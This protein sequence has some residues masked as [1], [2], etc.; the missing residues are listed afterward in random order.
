MTVLMLMFGGRHA[1]ISCQLSGTST[2]SDPRQ[3]VLIVK[4]FA[5]LMVSPACDCSGRWGRGAAALDSC[6]HW[7]KPACCLHWPS[8]KLGTHMCTFVVTVTLGMTEELHIG[9]QDAKI[10]GP[11]GADST[12]TAVPILCAVTSDDQ[13]NL[14]PA[15]SNCSLLQ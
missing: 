5:H 8:A 3:F 11:G 9:G 12:D 7:Q 13:V 2:N 10:N 15:T 4:K 1:L 14:S 6:M